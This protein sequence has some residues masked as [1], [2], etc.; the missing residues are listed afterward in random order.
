MST[1]NNIYISVINVL[2]SVFNSICFMNCL[3]T[4]R[5]NLNFSVIYSINSVICFLSCTKRI[6]IIAMNIYC[7]GYVINSID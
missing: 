1:K 4:V 2:Y 3:F 7:R 5:I 6:I